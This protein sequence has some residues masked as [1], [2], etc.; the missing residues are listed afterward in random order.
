ML[1]KEKGTYILI[2]Q[3]DKAATL[4]IG[5][6]G[7]F[8]LAVGWYTYVGSAFGPGGLNRRLKH[9]LSPVKKAH[10]HID[11]LRTVAAVETVWYLADKTP[12]EHQWADVLQSLPD[13]S[14]PVPRF[15]ASDCHCQTHLVYFPVEPLFAQFCDWSGG[16]L[17]QWTPQSGT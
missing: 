14:I 16:L 3:M 2:L 8:D 13:S 17:Q 1:P 10:W 11:Y 12:Y 6:R 4:T 5:K 15:G 7:S 9:H